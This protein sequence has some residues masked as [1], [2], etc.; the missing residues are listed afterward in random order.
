LISKGV[1]YQRRPPA[2]R[3]SHA[4]LSLGCGVPSSAISI[5]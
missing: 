4:G 2:R 3:L 5:L 1:I